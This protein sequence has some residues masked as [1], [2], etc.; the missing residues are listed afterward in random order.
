M[1]TKII[2]MLAFMLVLAAVDTATLTQNT[3]FGQR[4]RVIVR[5]SRRGVGAVYVNNNAVSGNAVTIFSRESNGTLTREGAVS[6]GGRG[7]GN[8]LESQG[9]LIL[10]EGNEWL[11]AANPGSDDISIF[12]VVEGSGLILLDRVPSG[13]D[14]PLSLTVC[15]DLLYVLN[16]GSEGNITGFHIGPDGRL[17]QIPGSTRQL[18]T[19][20]S[21][22]CPPLV[23]DLGDPGAICSAAGPGQI[24]FN[25]N[26]DV[27]VVTERLTNGTGLIDTYTVGDDGRT[28]GF[29][30]R[31]PADGLS[32]FGFDFAKRNLLVVTHNFF[33]GPGLGAAASYRVLEDDS[34]ATVTPNLPNGQSASCWTII[35][36]N[37]R[38]AYITNPISATVS[39]YSIARDGGLS[40]LN[41][42]A[43]N[44]SGRD[45]R[46]PALSDNGRFLYVLNNLTATVSAFVVRGDGGLTFLGDVSGFPSGAVGLAAR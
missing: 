39:S 2:A 24:Q 22:P 5:G 11:F 30:T 36:N 6:T 8:I 40:L 4:A 14:R 27:L 21:E 42:V 12:A 33:D 38:Y 16:A 37:G 34:V 25:P 1:K 3:A 20:A 46:D 7:T 26:G 17:T 13:G 31:P 41:P 18:S 19:T 28:T 29:T 23:V 15:E 10:S 9:T 45:P 35:T 32:P 43:A 44:L